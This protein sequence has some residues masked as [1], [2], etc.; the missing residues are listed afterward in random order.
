M[1]EKGGTQ[2]WKV[3]A[4][5]SGAEEELRAESFRTN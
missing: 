4:A 5:G 1:R 3:S 2:F